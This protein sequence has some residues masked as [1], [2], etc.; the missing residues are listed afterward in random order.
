[1]LGA[2]NGSQIDDF[3]S[4]GK[5]EDLTVDYISQSYF[6][7]PRGS[8]RNDSDRLILFKQ[9]LRDYQSMYYD[10]GAYDMLFS[11]FKQLC[12]KA[13]SEKPNYVLIRLKIKMK[14]N[15]VCSMKVEAHILNA[16]VKL[17]LFRVYEKK[18]KQT[19]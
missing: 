16:Y 9:T 4:R 18:Q 12:H 10:S 17:K 6:G 2:R 15:I 13:W 7:L 14:V 3:F 8:I 19:F 1:M 5:H 11:E